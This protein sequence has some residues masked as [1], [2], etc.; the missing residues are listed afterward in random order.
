MFSG[1][2]NYFVLNLVD[3]AWHDNILNTMTFICIYV[4]T[5]CDFKHKLYC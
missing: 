2:N 4:E 5:N 3:L 1:S